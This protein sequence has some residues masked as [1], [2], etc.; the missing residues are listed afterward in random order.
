[1]HAGAGHGYDSM[2]HLLVPLNFFMNE[3]NSFILL[4]CY[5]IERLIKILFLQNA[6]EILVSLDTFQGHLGSLLFKFTLSLAH[7]N[8]D[9]F[10]IVNKF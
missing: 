3:T 1:M 6:H 2:I 5:Y 10:R 9:C 4:H 7:V 8:R